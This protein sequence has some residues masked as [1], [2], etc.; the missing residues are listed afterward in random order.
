MQLMFETFRRDIEDRLFEQT[1]FN[2]RIGS[3]V[4]KLAMLLYEY[5][6]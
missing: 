4:T 6:L 2:V 1:V 3:N 5:F